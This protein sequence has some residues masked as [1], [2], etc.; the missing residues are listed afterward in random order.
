MLDTTLVKT[1]PAEELTLD[2]S[3][4]PKVE[5]TTE[6]SQPS[7][8]EATEGGKAILQDHD[9]KESTDEKVKAH[10]TTPKYPPH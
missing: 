10:D 3:T 6:P 1:A 4:I 8:E 7:A 5:I 2:E 9:N